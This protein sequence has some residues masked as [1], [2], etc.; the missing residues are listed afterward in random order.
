[1][2]M[3]CIFVTQLSYGHI[4]RYY[5]RGVPSLAPA[6]PSL[7]KMKCDDIKAQHIHQMTNLKPLWRWLTPSKKN[8][9]KQP[10]PHQAPTR[11]PSNTNENLNINNANNNSYQSER[12]LPRKPQ[13]AVHRLQE[14]KSPP[15]IPLSG[16]PGLAFK[17]RPLYRRTSSRPASTREAEG[18]EVG[19]R[20]GG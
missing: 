17:S 19:G 20:D 5:A 4:T 14:L 1:M 11:T 16:S 15:P 3:P 12:H 6:P 8:K 18:G 9:N 10:K 7:P 2:G 13:P